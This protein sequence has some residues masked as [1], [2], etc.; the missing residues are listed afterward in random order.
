MANKWLR[1][2]ET[3]EHCLK[4]KHLK[5]L[6]ALPDRMHLMD[7]LPKR[8]RAAEVGVHIGKYTRK[9]LD[10]NNPKTLY[11]VDHWEDSDRKHSYRNCRYQKV[12]EKF[13]EDINFG[14]VN[15]IKED[16]VVALNNFSDNFFDWVYIDTLH[17]Y[18]QVKEELMVSA[19]KVKNNGYIAGHDYTDGDEGSG[20]KYGVKRA[21]RE[22]CVEHD[23]EFKYLTFDKDNNPSYALQKI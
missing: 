19:D 2:I 13:A 23:Y 16:S 21:V 6:K 8:S 11:L 5:N 3:K 1:E 9:I 14:R 17:D 20:Y 7:K 22:F 15:L 12:K 4:N 10:I 18:S